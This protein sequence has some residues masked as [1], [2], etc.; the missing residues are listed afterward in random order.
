MNLKPSFTDCQLRIIVCYN[1]FITVGTLSPVAA[2]PA[3]K[4][5]RIR[6]HTTWK[7]HKE[8]AR[9]IHVSI[10]DDNGRVEISQILQA[11]AAKEGIDPALFSLYGSNGAPVAQDEGSQGKLCTCGNF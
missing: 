7:N 6:F 2:G 4:T 8:A 5:I 11:V 10:T 1:G 3:K 9:I